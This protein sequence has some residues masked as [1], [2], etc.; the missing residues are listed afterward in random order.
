MSKSAGSWQKV[1]PEI[2]NLGEVLV[3]T[4]QAAE[5]LNKSTERVRQ[6]VRAGFIHR[7]PGPDNAARYR[8]IDV[9]RGYV[10]Y[11]EDEKRRASQTEAQSRIQQARAREI[12][13]RNAHKEATLMEVSDHFEV[14]DGLCGLFRDQMSGLAAR[15]TRDL[16]V[17]RTIDTAVRD[18]FNRIADFARENASRLA[19]NRDA[20][21]IVPAND[22]GGMGGGEPDA[23]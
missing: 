5:L 10:S 1:E 12:D 3:S 20:N 21:A 11:R 23:S 7:Q 8:L 2:P 16:M 18:I 15:V 17:R 22:T 9:T 13:L 19:K 14:I 4:E 6:I